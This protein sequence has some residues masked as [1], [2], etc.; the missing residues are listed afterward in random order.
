MC[1]LWPLAHWRAYRAKKAAA[2]AF[3]VFALYSPLI[4]PNATVYGALEPEHSEMAGQLAENLVWSQLRTAPNRDAHPLGIQTL[5]VERDEGKKG[6]PKRRARVYQFNYQ[7]QRSRVV[8]VDIAQQTIDKVQTINSVHLPLN[9]YEITR[10][11]KLIETDP[12]IMRQLNQIQS[13]KGL[14]LLNDLST[15][16]LKASIYEPE[17]DDHECVKQR[18]ALISLFDQTRTV[19]T[20]EPV[21]NLQTSIVTTLTHSE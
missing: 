19:F 12:I 21:V 2:L 10:A 5:S 6:D 20:I 16:E 11:R 15:I 9:K 8:L 4:L 14:I 1:T 13:N 3:S 18:C 17:N 7:T